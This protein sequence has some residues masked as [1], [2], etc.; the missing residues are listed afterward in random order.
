[1]RWLGSVVKATVATSA[2]GY[3]YRRL[4][5]EQF[6]APKDAMMAASAVGLAVG[7]MNYLRRRAA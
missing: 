5:G 1:M 6:A 3:G 4:R 2:L 7:T